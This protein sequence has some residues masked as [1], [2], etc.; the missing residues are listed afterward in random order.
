MKHEREH[1]CRWSIIVAVYNRLDEARELLDSAEKLEGE[2]DRFEILF[3]D[4]GSRD[5]F[6]E[7]I[8]GYHSPTGLRVR[9]VYQENKGP[10]AARNHGMRVAAGEYF[11]FVD[12]DCTF[13][14]R[15]LAEIER[16][17][18]ERQLDAFGG[19]DTCHP[20]FSPLQ[21]AINYSMTSFIGTG[22]TR[23]NTRRVGKYYPRSFNMGISRRVRD[24]VGEMNGLRH[25]QDMDYSMRVHAAGFRVGLVPGAFVYHKRRATLPRFFRQVFN[26][27]ATR[28][29]LSRAHR[30]TLKVIHLLPAMLV[31]GAAILLATGI[32]L[33]AARIAWAIAGGAYLAVVLL[34]LA[35][36]WGRHRSARVA[37]LSVVTLSTQVLAYGLG[38]IWGAWRVARGKE[39]RGFTRNYYGNENATTGTRAA[40]RLLLFTQTYPRAGGETFI[41]NEIHYLADAFDEVIIL[42]WM[43]RGTP[44]RPVPPNCRVLPALLGGPTSTAWRGIFSL[45]P[46]G[47]FARHF[48]TERAYTSPARAFK[49]ISVAIFCRAILASRDFKRVNNEFRDATLYFYWGIGSAYLLPFIKGERTRVARFHGGDLYA[50]RKRGGY[51][52]FRRQVYE[53]LTRALFVSRDGME[54]ALARHSRYIREARVSYLG[55]ADHGRAATRDDASP[56]VHL[57]SCSR[58]I[59]VKRVRLILDALRLV[60][61]TPVAW[62]HLGGGPGWKELAREAKHCPAN[63]E[64]RLPGEMDYRQVIEYYL[65][66]PVD[67]FLNVSSSE[68]VPVSIMEAISFDVPVLATRVGGMPEIVTGEVGRLVPPDVSPAELSV[69]L[70]EMIRDRRDFHPRSRWESSFSAAVNYPSFIREYLLDSPASPTDDGPPRQQQ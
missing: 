5:G 10:G 22:G 20:S 27:G 25:G 32:V 15:W 54:Y 34:A 9:A 41:E 33:P 50:E 43:G 6:R 31:A 36:S 19:P 64:I 30:G 29:V 17:V 52:P 60:T 4:D 37:A 26:W 12:S 53:S 44:A 55:T 61:G 63:V 28:V 11:I 45:A 65:H 47:Y 59:P 38:M 13:P 67:L 49:Y 40:R 18:D 14:P 1:A 62:T 21:K 42:P 66:H 46:V 39:A 70:Q 35:Q 16:A 7:F 8:E 24:T 58:V 68:G 48:F 57:L 3:V 69:H 23:G 56:R 51:I 2:R